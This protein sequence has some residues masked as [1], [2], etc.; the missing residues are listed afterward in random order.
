MLKL[1]AGRAH[2]LV[3]VDIDSDSRQL[4]RAE[5]MLAGLPN[6]TLRQGDM[7]QLPFGDGEFDTI[8]LDDVLGGAEQP[9]A[10]LKEAARLL[11]NNGRLFILVAL[12]NDP[13]EELRRSIAGWGAAAGLRLA[14]ARVV[15]RQDPRW[16]LS[17]AIVSRSHDVAA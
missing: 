8:I 5:M 7:Y 17:V 3:G 16:L 2:R 4:A 14:P 15:P 11:R 12:K 1:L 9:V 6:C 13:G 10:V